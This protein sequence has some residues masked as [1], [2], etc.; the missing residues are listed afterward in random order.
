MN[1]CRDILNELIVF[2]SLVG[3]NDYWGGEEWAH[4]SDNL[5]AILA[6]ADYLSHHGHNF[7]VKD[8]LQAM[9]KTHE[10]QGV[11]CIDNS[12]NRQGIDHVMFVK[13][14]STAVVS[15]MLGCSFE[16]SCAAISLACVD[17][18]ALRTYRHAPN[19]GPR[20]SWAAGDTLRR[21]VQLA[22][23][24]KNDEPGYPSALTAPEWG[25]YAVSFD[26]KAFHMA[27]PFA[28]HIINNNSFK[29][30]YPTEF[31]AQTALEAAIK[32]HQ[33]VDGRWNDIEKITIETLE[34]GFRIINKTGPLYNPADRDH[35]IQ[36]IVAIGLI[37]GTLEEEHYEDHIAANPLIDELRN[38]MDVIHN[39]EFTASYQDQ[40]KR[41][42]TN[43]VTVHFN[44]GSSTER[45]QIDYALGQPQ[46][47]EE[48]QPALKK[49][50][51]SALEAHYSSEH[52]QYIAET[53]FNQ[54]TLLTMPCQQ[55]ID[56]LCQGCKETQAELLSN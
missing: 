50:L 47:R 54:S 19:T 37:Y 46:R 12:L 38:R 35:C 26:D 21:A 53:I 20:K 23:M 25:F 48:A 55:F 9:I 22:L 44:N 6:V 34:S 32:L 17:G 56:M 52:S 24:A 11:F 40:Q 45:I 49:K 42:V 18:Q 39:Q 36:Y 1:I 2:R 41:A 10:I 4:P 7:T 29:L 3:Y 28:E 16:Q 33:Q 14:A 15:H 13:L 43:A 5:G 51:L 31:H 27:Q 30:P 8:I